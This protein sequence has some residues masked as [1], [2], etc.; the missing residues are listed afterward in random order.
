MNMPFYRSHMGNE[1]NNSYEDKLGNCLIAYGDF[2]HY[3]KSVIELMKLARGDT[4]GSKVA[5]LVLLSAYNSYKWSLP[6]VEL[7][8]LD[9][10]Y[11]Q[12]AMNV[13]HGR[14]YSCHEPHQVISDGQQHFDKLWAQWQHLLPAE[15]E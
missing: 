9:D 2:E 7:G 4:G 15:D 5:A 11:Y 12:H 3:A 1:Q 14:L 6:I 10:N 8:N 13:I